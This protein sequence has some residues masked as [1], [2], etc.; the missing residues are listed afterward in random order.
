[1]FMFVVQVDPW[2]ASSVMLWPPLV[3]YSILI[4]ATHVPGHT[5]YL[6][7]SYGFS[8]DSINIEDASFSVHTPTVLDVML[9]NPLCTARSTG[10]YSCHIDT[11][12][13]TVL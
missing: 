4:H 1:M 3:N 12:C 10:H 11:H 2:S 5:L 6:M 13:K 9:S 7:L 8:I